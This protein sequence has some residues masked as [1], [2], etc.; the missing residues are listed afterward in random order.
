M[1][2]DCIP[3]AGR[4]RQHNRSVADIP[5]LL[6]KVRFGPRSGHGSAGK[7]VGYG[8]Q[9]DVPQ[10]PSKRGLGLLRDGRRA[11]R[12]HARGLDDDF[13]VLCPNVVRCFWR[14]GIERARGIRLEFAFIPLFTDAEIKRPRQNDGR[15]PFIGMPMRH[16]LRAS[17]KF[18]SL[19]VHTR[20]CWVAI[21]YRVLR[22]SGAYGRFELNFIW[23]FD[24]RLGALTV[25]R[26]TAGYRTSRENEKYLP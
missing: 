3:S 4:L 9:A 6:A 21:Y 20:F 1:S 5:E 22:R 17:W 16:D 14:F 18:G 25:D 26:G 24:D 23:Q 8:Q 2:L 13:T 10:C 15:A 12:S 7:D 19:N 11:C